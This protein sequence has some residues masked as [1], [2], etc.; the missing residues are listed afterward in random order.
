MKDIKKAIIYLLVLYKNT[1]NKIKRTL[2]NNALLVYNK[3][4]K[5]NKKK[6]TTLDWY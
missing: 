5:I 6:R 2:I 3:V 4:N 1:L